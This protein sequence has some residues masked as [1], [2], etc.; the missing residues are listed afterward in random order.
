MRTKTLLLS[1]AAMAAGLVSSV[2]QSNVYSVNVVGYVNQ[3]LP[4]GTLVAVANPLDNGTNTL[5]SGAVLD[6]QWFYDF[7]KGCYLEPK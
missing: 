2:A 3:V 7:N 1:A 4:A 6:W 5:D